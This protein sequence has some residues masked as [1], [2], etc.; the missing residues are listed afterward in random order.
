MKEAGT[1]KN[2]QSCG[3]PRKRDEKGGGTNA[4]GSKSAMY[5]SHCFEAGK[6]KMPDLKAAEMQEL[7]K[8]KIREAGFPGVAAWLFTR[9]I[10]KLA[11]WKQG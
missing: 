8:G 10:P 11:R 6:F 1:Y 4:D 2:C 9:N 5:C 3:M 7:V